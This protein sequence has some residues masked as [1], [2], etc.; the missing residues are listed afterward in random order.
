MVDGQYPP[1]RLGHGTTVARGRGVWELGLEYSLILE[2]ALR[3]LC[4]HR[5]GVVLALG[6]NDATLP[7]RA[8][9][10]LAAIL[11]AYTL[12]YPGVR[13]VEVA[14]AAGRSDAA[15]RTL[16][17]AYLQDTHRG[18]LKST[19]PDVPPDAGPEPREAK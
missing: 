12:I 1:I 15:M 9:E 11:R 7:A 8:Y 17:H 10:G 14:E 6:P 4:R 3:E 16:I 19:V 5:I 18:V 13:F 2:A